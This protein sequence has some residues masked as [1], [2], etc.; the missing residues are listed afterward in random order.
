MCG[1][2]VSF[3]IS[4]AIWV[5]APTIR[6]VHCIC[7]VNNHP[8]GPC[9]QE[10]AHLV[11][12][13]HRME[14]N[15]GIYSEIPTGDSCGNLAMANYSLQFGI[16]SPAKEPVDRKG[17]RGLVSAAVILSLFLYS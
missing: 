8:P 12:F 13:K 2:Y 9:T 7:R 1:S 15:S 10:P 3:V 6:K 4:T 14:V 16:V 17:I 11:L 5:S